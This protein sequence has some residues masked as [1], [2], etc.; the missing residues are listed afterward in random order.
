[1]D[2][3][4]NGVWQ[5]SEGDFWKQSSTL[6]QLIQEIQPHAERKRLFS[7][8]VVMY[9]SFSKIFQKTNIKSLA[10]TA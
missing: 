6:E 4:A 10:Q 1:M 9:K 3:E 8:Q 7:F 2:A 5:W